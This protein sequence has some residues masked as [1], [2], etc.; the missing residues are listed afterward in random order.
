MELISVL[1]YLHHEKR[2]AH[3]DLKCENVLL[4]RYH[5]IRVIDFGLS[6]MFSE[7]SPTLQTA[8][9]SPAYAAPEMIQGQPYTQAADIWSSGIVLFAITAGYLPFDDDNVQ[10]LLQKVV[11]TDPEYPPFFS[12]QLIDLLDKML[13]KEPDHRMTTEGVKNHPW[14]SQTEYLALLQEAGQGIWESDE[15]PSESAIDHEIVGKMTGMGVDCH[16]LTQLLLTD[17]FT[18]L[19]ALYR[20]LRREKIMERNRDLFTKVPAVAMTLKP[21]SKPIGVFKPRGGG[22]DAGA[23]TP[24]MGVFNRVQITVPSLPAGSS[25]KTTPRSSGPAGVGSIGGRRLSRPVA[26]RRPVSAGG[27]GSAHET[28]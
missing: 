2:V 6:N 24:R 12:P 10:R 15:G 28:P 8:C 13:C 16:K 23:E 7:L 11:Y 22:S 17:D 26:V 3:R 18:D 21:Q 20:L 14:F 5:N 19:T 27:H 9:G 4:D 1:D 25:G